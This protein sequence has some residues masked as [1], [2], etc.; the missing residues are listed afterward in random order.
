MGSLVSTLIISL[1]L[2][3]SMLDAATLDCLSRSKYERAYLHCIVDVDRALYSWQRGGRWEKKITLEP[4][5]T[6]GPT[7]WDFQKLM[8]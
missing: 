7:F 2:D 6:M 8:R 4:A 1:G 3:A 5:W